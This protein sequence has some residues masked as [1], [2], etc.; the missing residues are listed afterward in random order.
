MRAATGRRVRANTPTGARLDRTLR[1]AFGALCGG[2]ERA[3]AD[4]AL[5]EIDSG[6]TGGP[7]LHDAPAGAALADAAVA[8][9]SP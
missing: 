9:V 5:N 4:R 1:Q 6:S 8:H 7:R 2:F 3:S